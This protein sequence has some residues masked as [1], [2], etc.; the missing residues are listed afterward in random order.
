MA[1]LVGGASGPCPA[2]HERGASQRAGRAGPSARTLADRSSATT[3]GRLSPSAADAL[4]EALAGDALSASLEAGRRRRSVPR[5]PRARRRDRDHGRQAEA[6]AHGQ[7]LYVYALPEHPWF[8]MLRA[9]RRRWWRARARSRRTGARRAAGRR[10]LEYLCARPYNRARLRAPDAGSRTPARSAGPA[11]R[12][13]PV[14]RAIR[15]HH[16]RAAPRIS[17]PAGPRACARCWAWLESARE[18]ESNRARRPSA[19]QRAR[20]RGQPRR[21]KGDDLAR[22]PRR[23]SGAPPPRWSRVRGVP[24]CT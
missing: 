11:R 9:L 18:R 16:R 14:R 17:R 2:R 7:P 8:R 10:E 24:S 13:A 19:L 23:A 5:L 4:G 1:V 12:R 21:G 20:T 15:H 22:P 6:T 3:P